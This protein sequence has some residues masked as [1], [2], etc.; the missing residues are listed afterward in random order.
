MSFRFSSFTAT[1]AA[2]ALLI[3]GIPDSA[4]ANEQVRRDLNKTYEELTPGEHIAIRAAAKAAYKAKKFNTL[5]I[6]ADP[7]NMPLSNIREEGFQNKLANILAEGMGARIKYHWQPL[8]DRGL[9][10]STFDEQLCDVMFDIPST[11]DRLLTTEPVYK[12]PY[13]L[14]Y[15][16]DKGL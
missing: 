15:R 6:C 1:L 7:G 4:D 3:G 11:F 12:T 13:V 8:I 16:N 10:R 2:A 5:N 9:T 14:V